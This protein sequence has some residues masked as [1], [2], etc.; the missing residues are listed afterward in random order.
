M[1][2]MSKGTCLP[3]PRHCTHGNL[4]K[5]VMPEKIESAVTE[6]DYSRDVTRQKRQRTLVPDLE[7]TF[8]R[9]AHVVKRHLVMVLVGESHRGKNGR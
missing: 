7:S 2:A 3:G 5:V 9:E 4:A 6:R 8:I 1:N